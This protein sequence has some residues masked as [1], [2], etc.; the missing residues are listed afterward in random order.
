MKKYLVAGLIVV[1]SSFNVNAEEVSKDFGWVAKQDDKLVTSQITNTGNKG[2]QLI[3]GCE[4]KG[5][6]LTVKYIINGKEVEMFIVETLS[7]QGKDTFPY[8][9]IYGLNSMT[10]DMVLEQI[11]KT[12]QGFVISRFENGDRARYQESRKTG[13]KSMTPI[14][15]GN[16]LFTG[17]EFIGEFTAD[18]KEVCGKSE[19]RQF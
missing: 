7:T 18:L 6:P 9:S 5:E 13:D 3:I 11:E 2:G 10:S 15:V 17:Y 12:D 16:E 8:V 14:P 4:K 1:L 19:S